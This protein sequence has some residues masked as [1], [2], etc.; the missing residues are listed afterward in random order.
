MVDASEAVRHRQSRFDPLRA[1]ARLGLSRQA[2]GL[3]AGTND[4]MY[5]LQYDD[6]DGRG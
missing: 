1:V 2:Q 5:L 4:D 6:R 3:A